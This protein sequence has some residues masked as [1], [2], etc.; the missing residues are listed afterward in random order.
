[1]AWELDAF[2]HYHVDVDNCKCALPWWCE[3][4]HKFPV[5]GLSIQQ[6]FGNILA[7]QIETKMIS[8][9]LEFS[10]HFEVLVTTWPHVPNYFCEQKLAW[11]S[12]D[13]VFKTFWC[14]RWPCRCMYG[15][16]RFGKRVWCKVWKWNWVGRIPKLLWF[17]FLKIHV[18]KVETLLIPP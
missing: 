18:F 11:Q 17:P 9:I 7:S 13:Q 16:I 2:C 15:R 6:V 5:V 1:M 14:C 3:E 4:E 8:P 12:K 10:L